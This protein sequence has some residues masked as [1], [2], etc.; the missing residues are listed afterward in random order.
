MA[1]GRFPSLKQNNW[2]IDEV[3]SS[4]S[5]KKHHFRFVCCLIKH[6]NV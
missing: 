3:K 5:L 6:H 1:F 4:E 2:F